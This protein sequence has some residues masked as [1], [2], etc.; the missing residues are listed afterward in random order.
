MFSYSSAVPRSLHEISDDLNRRQDKIRD[1]G[2]R[3]ELPG[4]EDCD[5]EARSEERHRAELSSMK[6]IDTVEA[7]LADIVERDGQLHAWQAVDLELA[8][9]QAPPSMPARR[10]DCCTA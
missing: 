2:E 9:R 3:G 4:D 10:A 1:A 8:R 7:A 6:V 5:E